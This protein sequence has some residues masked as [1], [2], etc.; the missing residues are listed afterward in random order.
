MRQHAESTQIAFVEGEQ[1]IAD[2]EKP[3]RANGACFY[4]RELEANRL[5]RE[6]LMNHFGLREPVT[7]LNSLC[8]SV[9]S[10]PRVEIQEHIYDR[11]QRTLRLTENRNHST[12]LIV[13]GCAKAQWRCK[14]VSPNDPTELITPS[15]N[16]RRERTGRK[17]RSALYVDTFPS[18]NAS[19]HT[20]GV[21]LPRAHQEHFIRRRY[22]LDEFTIVTPKTQRKSGENYVPNSRFSLPRRRIVNHPETIPAAAHQDKF[23]E[24]AHECSH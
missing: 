21:R 19:G 15:A 6:T 20:G 8:S 18:G 24:E 23:L 22:S 3:Q 14:V 9:F 16:L 13:V 7:G 12:R 5:Y 10:V 11:D 1:N 2:P 17:S 4:R